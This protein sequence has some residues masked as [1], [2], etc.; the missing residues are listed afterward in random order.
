[1][2]WPLPSHC[3]FE[4]Q[5]QLLGDEDSMGATVEHTVGP[6]EEEKERGNVAELEEL[7]AGSDGA[8]WIQKRAKGINQQQSGDEIFERKVEMLRQIPT[9]E[10][11]M[12]RRLQRNVQK[13]LKTELLK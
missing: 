10:R 5:Q 3:P 12:L 4:E 13:M 6:L 9:E 8:E 1:M 11:R 7:F 2:T